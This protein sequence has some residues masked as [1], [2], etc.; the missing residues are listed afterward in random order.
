MKKLRKALALILALVMLVSVVP[1]AAVA[2]EPDAVFSVAKVN[3]TDYDGSTPIVSGDTVDVDIILTVGADEVLKAWMLGYHFDAAALTYGGTTFDSVWNG[4]SSDKGTYILVGGSVKPSARVSDTEIVAATITFTANSSFSGLTTIEAGLGTRNYFSI[5][6]TTIQRK[7]I[8]A[9][10]CDFTIYAPVDKTALKAKLDEAAALDEDD[11]TPRSW[12]ALPGVVSASQA[13]Y[14]DAFALQSDIDTALQN[15]TDAIN[16]LVEVGNK[17]QLTTAVNNARIEAAKDCYTPDSLANLVA[18]INAAQIVLDDDNATQP[19]IDAQTILV[20]QAIN[21]LVLNNVTVRFLNADG[22]VFDEQSVPFGGSATAPATN[23]VKAADVYNTYTF[24]SWSGNYTN[25]TANVDIT[26]V[27]APTPIEYTI[28]FTDE[29]DTVISTQNY[30][31]G[32]TVNEPEEPTKQE[33]DTYTYTFAGWSPEVTT[34]TGNATYKATFTSTYKEYTITFVN[35]NDAELAK[36]TLHWGDTVTAPAD[37]SKPQDDTYTYTF[38]GWDKEVVAVA[39]DATYKAEFTPVYREYTVTFYNGE[40]VVSTKTDY[41]WGDVVVLPDNPGKPA[42]DTYTYTFAGWSPE[43]VNVAGNAEYVAQFTPNYI[44][45]SVK[46]VDYDDSEIA[47][48]TLHWGDTVTPPADPTRAADETYTY[49]FAGWD[50]SVNPVSGDITYKATYTPTYIDYTIKFVNYDDSELATLTLHWGDEVTPPADPSKPAD[51][52]YTYTFSGWD[53]DVVAVAGDATYKA[54]YSEAVNQYKV[55]FLNYDESV[56]AEVMYDYNATPVAPEGTP[57][58]PDDETFYYVFKSWAPEFAPVQGEQVYTAQFDAFYLEADY[59][60]VNA[61]VDEAMKYQDSDLYTSTSYNRLFAAVA[62]V[63]YT[64]TIDKQAQVDAYAAAI[65]DAIGKLVST[66]EY[67]AFYQKCAEVNNDNNQYTVDS[68]MAF[69]AAF[70]AIGAK[71]DFNTEDA[72]Q[73]QVNAALKELEDAYALLEAASLTIDGADEYLDNDEIRIKSNTDAESTTLVAN[74]GGAGTAS[75]VFTD[76][77]GSVITSVNK[78]YGTGTKVELVQG[79]EVKLTKYVV[80]YGDI[81]G[82]GQ[83][84]IADI[85]LAKKMA[86]STE[87]FTVYQIAAAKCGG[88]DVDVAAVIALAS[89]I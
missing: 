56:F 79:G 85:R 2:D 16:A 47:S 41:H 25:V 63:D 18:A 13:V 59:T 89:A 4:T 6:E 62:A 28:T 21:D 74:D 52:Q 36:Y 72:T 86:V 22:S 65:M 9:Q 1:F 10:G 82:D 75:L 68:F 20:N 84:S 51:A 39:G 34:V 30:H 60:A 54:V 11:Y 44:D 24:V 35:Y 49:E 19:E 67:D 83:V 64:L 80:V 26:P 55:T 42:D 66:T 77:K 81:N 87:G 76:T 8:I 37:P 7:D 43:V 70:A 17:F 78:T 12:E 73:E 46:F 32:D 23:P 3:G 57:V 14:D 69:E 5:G 58:K 48:Y 38:S 15:L 50:P 45:Y 31:Y 40:E 33:D 61:A 53:K 71:K 29:N 27:F 88:A